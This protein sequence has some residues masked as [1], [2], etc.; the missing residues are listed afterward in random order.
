MTDA[1]KFLQLMISL[2]KEQKENQQAEMNKVG[3]MSKMTYN[4]HINAGFTPEQAME[5]TK[6]IITTSLATLLMNTNK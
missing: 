4:A 2:G 5:M 6:A 3:E 1:E